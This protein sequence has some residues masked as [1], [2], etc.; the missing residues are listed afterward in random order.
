T[1]VSRFTLESGT[2]PEQCKTPFSTFQS[3]NGMDQKSFPTQMRSWVLSK[4]AE[5]S[6][7]FVQEVKDRTNTTRIVNVESFM[8]IWFYFN[9]NCSILLN[10]FPLMLLKVSI[11]SCNFS[12]FFFARLFCCPKSS[13]RL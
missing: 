7:F 6:D 9:S 5:N 12:G 10:S 8:M 13:L 1:C 3:S 11:I 4:L 2:E